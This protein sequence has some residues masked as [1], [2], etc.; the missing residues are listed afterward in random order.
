MKISKVHST[1]H[2]FPY[3]IEKFM[4]NSFPGSDSDI[5]ALKYLLCTTLYPSALDLYNETWRKQTHLQ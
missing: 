5:L 3:Y 1:Q 2:M 4:L